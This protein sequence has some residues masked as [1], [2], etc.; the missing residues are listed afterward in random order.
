[1]ALPA[2]RDTGEP[3]AFLRAIQAA[4]FQARHGH[5]FTRGELGTFY[6][7]CAS[8]PTFKCFLT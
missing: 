4:I 2:A 8:A 5:C 3:A 7:S 6:V 1:V